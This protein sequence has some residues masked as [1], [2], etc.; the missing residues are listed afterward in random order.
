MSTEAQI[1]EV[2]Q[3]ADPKPYVRKL[4]GTKFTFR[5][6]NKSGRDAI[7][8]AKRLGG[9]SGEPDLD[10]VLAM[11]DFLTSVLPVSQRDAFRALDVDMDTAADLM[12]CYQE[13]QGPKASS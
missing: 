6:I 9:A 12:K 5:P 13:S 4:S 11:Y 7:E 3:G 1:T 2:E 8:A 10:A